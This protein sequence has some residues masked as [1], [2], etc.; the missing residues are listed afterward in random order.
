MLSSNPPAKSQE[1]H[2]I[3]GRFRLD[4]KRTRAIPEILRWLLRVAQ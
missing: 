2:I 4:P 3:G 1:N